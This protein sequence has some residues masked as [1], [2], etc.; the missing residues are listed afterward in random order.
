MD[1]AVKKYLVYGFSNV[2]KNTGTWA[3]GDTSV[4][5]LNIDDNTR[6]YEFDFTARSLDNKNQRQKIIIY[7][8]GFKTHEFEFTEPNDFSGF[9]FK[10][11]GS[12]FKKGINEL[13]FKYSYST[14]PKELN[15]S[16]DGRK[17]SVLF[18]EMSIKVAGQ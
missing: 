10:A 12:L 5:F 16:S 17:L 2:E 14:T 15:F 8:N 6:D 9:S 18:K 3:Q 7:I 4:M 13:V 1:A 11:P